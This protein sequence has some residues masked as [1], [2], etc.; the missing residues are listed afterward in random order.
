MEA[1]AVL[2]EGES[3][4][5]SASSDDDRPSSHKIELTSFPF[6]LFLSGRSTPEDA[7]LWQDS[8]IAPLKRIV[9]FAHTQGKSERPP[10]PFLSSTRLAFPC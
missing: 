3:Q 8:Q 5:S 6:N 4:N 10:P 2:P 7:G 9:D 1:T